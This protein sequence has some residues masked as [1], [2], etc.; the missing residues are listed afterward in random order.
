MPLILPTLKEKTSDNYE[1]ESNVIELGFHSGSEESLVYW[2]D[3]GLLY[4]L[5]TFLSMKI[6][7]QTIA[8]RSILVAIGLMSLLSYGGYSI[9]SGKNITD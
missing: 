1:Y 6:K 4:T 3:Y 2:Y 9:Y 7:N 8:P 5:V